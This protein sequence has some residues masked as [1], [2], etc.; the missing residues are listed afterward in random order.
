M[1]F[2]AFITVFLSSFS[3]SVADNARS[4]IGSYWV[5]LGYSG[6][7]D[8]LTDGDQLIIS[9]NFPVHS[10]VDIGVDGNLGSISVL[11]YDLFTYGVSV[12][13]SVHHK[14]ESGSVTFDP[15]ISIGIGLTALESYTWQY[16]GSS[17]YYSYYST[18]A[19]TSLLVPY[20]FS[21]G[22]EFTFGS[23][24]SLIPAVGFTGIANE[25]V[26]NTFRFGVQG[27]FMFTDNFSI[28][29]SYS[30][31]DESGKNFSLLGRYHL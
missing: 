12:E 19:Q 9:S 28:G 8:D 31:N 22:T 23:F 3:F 16:T 6:Y 17:Y 4:V 25:D 24:F 20:S 30:V 13:T 21:I 27:N 14:I 7:S 15:F 10:N 11:D 18:V 1:K 5:G 2:F 26:D 29:L